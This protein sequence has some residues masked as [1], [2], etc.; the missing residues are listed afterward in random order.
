MIKG[1][2]VNA[3]TFCTTFFARTLRAMDVRAENRGRP[4]HKAR[5]PATLVM[6]RNF[7]TPGHPG[8][9][10]RNIRRKFGPKCLCLCCSSEASPNTGKKPHKGPK[11]GQKSE[12]TSPAITSISGPKNGQKIQNSPAFPLLLNFLKPKS[13]PSNEVIG[14]SPNRETAPPLPVCPP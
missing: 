6:E 13:G 7:L 9:R 12:Q 3:N 14:T 5:C 11:K 1:K 4:H 2:K 10:V 8:V